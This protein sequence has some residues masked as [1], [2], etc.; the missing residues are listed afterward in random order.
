MFGG[1]GDVFRVAFVHVDVVGAAG[2][3][4]EVS[5][6]GGYRHDGW[7]NDVK[8]NALALCCSGCNGIASALI[9]NVSPDTGA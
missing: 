7:E 3:C 9:I 6:G 2:V 4:C 8:L 5:L 1:G